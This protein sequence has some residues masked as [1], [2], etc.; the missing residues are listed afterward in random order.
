M[1]SLAGGIAGVVVAPWII[2]ALVSFRPFPGF[3]VNVSANWQ[4]LAFVAGISVLSGAIFG[5]APAWQSSRVSLVPALK[6]EAGA[7]RMGRWHVR[8]LLVAAQLTISLAVLV[9]AGLC[10]ESLR[11]LQA[12]RAGF[13]ADKV[14]LASL[15]L[16]RAGYN[17]ARGR[18]FYRQLTERVT[19]LPGVEAAGFARVTPLGGGGMRITSLP[20][21]QVPSNE[22]PINL[23]M[24][25]VG[26]GWFRAMGIPLLRGRDFGAADTPTS[27]SVIIVNETLVNRYWPGHSGLGKHIQLG[28]FPGVPVR[29]FEVVG[30]VPDSKYRSLTEAVPPV[31]YFAMEQDYQPGMR[32]FV[33]STGALAAL[34]APLRRIV[35]ELDGNIPLYGMRTLAEQRNNSLYTARLAAFLLGVMSAIGLLLAAFGLYGVLA[36]AVEQRR[37]EIGIRMALGADRAEVLRHV[38]AQGMLPVLLGLAGGT[39][40]A[41]AGTRLIKTLLYGVAPQDPFTYAAAISALVAVA[42]VACLIPARRATRVDPMVALRYE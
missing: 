10:I 34:A 12:I 20:E 33:R 30:V 8:N 36:Y 41:L 25:V 40:A 5:L 32:I 22:K 9:A 2:D 1:I 3:A 35:S 15:D 13:D 42:L 31:M 21:G 16:G 7:I 26:S 39:A 37:R 18:E 24:N 14:M 17:E 4:T 19:A 6:E 28:G 23:S 29:E 27:P 11:G 38:V